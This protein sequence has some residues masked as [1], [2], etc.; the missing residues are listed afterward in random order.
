MDASAIRDVCSAEASELM[1][2]ATRRR[3]QAAAVSLSTIRRTLAEL[4]QL[5]EAPDAGG[6]AEDAQACVE[7]LVAAAEAGAADRERAVAGRKDAEIELLKAQLDAQVAR[8]EQHTAER[9]MVEGAL[10]RATEQLDIVDAERAKTEA[11][12]ARATEQRD[13]LMADKA[14][15]DAEAVRL[16]SQTER[17]VA[18]LDRLHGAFERLAEGRGVPDVLRSMASGF[19]GECARLALFTVQDDQL[20]C[21]QHTGFDGGDFEALPIPLAID[22]VLT[23]ALAGDRIQVLAMDE[24]A[25]HARVPFGGEPGHVLV[26]PLVARARPVGIVYADD[27]G[28]PHAGPSTMAQLLIV[29]DLLR[30]HAVARLEVLTHEPQTLKELRAYA[31]LLLEEVEYRY[32]TLATA[33]ADRVDVLRSLDANMQCARQIYAQRAAGEGAAAIGLLDA[34][35][36][37]LIETRASANFGR[38][39]AAVLEP[40]APGIEGGQA[41]GGHGW[42]PE[43]KS[44]IVSP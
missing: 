24:A 6:D 23:A 25:A 22:S 31:T 3:A 30:R 11:A 18:R 13:A 43:E 5:L 38:D 40:K 7:R 1:L 15:R 33:G 27:A 39:L 42:T 44:S 9:V 35:I 4:S 17:A 26:I 37:E 2:R 20:E 19:A 14:T 10:A 16:A 32:D 34:H 21:V 41:P 36:R 29:A 28:D 8:N 12:L